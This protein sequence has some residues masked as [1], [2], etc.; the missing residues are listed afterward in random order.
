MK[1]IRILI[2]GCV[3][4]A[5]I[6]AGSAG[7]QTTKV[8]A[9]ANVQ[10]HTYLKVRI[11]LDLDTLRLGKKQSRVFTPVL[12]DG[13]H[14]QALCPLTVNGKWRQLMYKRQKGDDTGQEVLTVVCTSKGAG[15]ISYADSCIY[16]PWM[17]G[18]QLLLA[19][20]ACGCGGDVM[21]QSLQTLAVKVGGPDSFPK[22]GAGS[23]PCSSARLREAPVPAKETVH[24]KVAKVTLYL[25]YLTF[26]INRTEI[27]PEFGNNRTELHKLRAALDSLNMLPDIRIELVSMTGYASPDGPY[28][29][30]DELAY[31]RTLALRDYLQNM[32]RYRELPFRTTSV[33]EDW[34]GLKKALEE[35]DMP[36]REELLQIIATDMEPDTKEGKMKILD[37]K[38]AYNLLKRDF[39]PQLRRTVCEIH[40]TE[41]YE[42]K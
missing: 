29:R 31:G 11:R 42:K 22:P 4:A 19:Q 24:H 32:P 34:Q 14:R 41:N 40:Y 23:E 1:R 36:Y 30:N 26:P 27:L 38:K 33:A 25:D 13:T 16:L 7:A 35:S 10:V 17:K 2:T 5:C 37:G 3:C 12:S 18:A 21:E 15:V 39:L 9:E 6:Y 28:R 8:H 20:D